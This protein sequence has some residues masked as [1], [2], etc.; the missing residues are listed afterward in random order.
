M[1]VFTFR[2]KLC[3]AVLLL[4]G[5]ATI[6]FGGFFQILLNAIIHEE[7]EQKLPIKNGTLAFGF[8]RDPPVPV[9]F[10]I[11]VFDVQNPD[12]VIA[13]KEA[14]SIVEK[15][16]YV[17]R[18]HL[19]KED[20]KWHQN[21]TV[22]YVQPQTYFFDREASVGPDTDTF[23]TINVPY[24]TI[25]TIMRFELP[26]LQKIIDAF[27][28]AKYENAFRRVSVHDI[29]WGYEDPVLEEAAELLKKFNITSSLINGKFGFYMEHN[30]TGDGM[31]NVFS[32]LDGNLDNYILVDR[33]NGL[34]KLTLWTTEY[35]NQIRGSD[36][37]QHPPYVTKD[38]SISIFDGYLQRSLKMCYNGSSSF[39][40]VRT[41]HFTVPYSEFAT[42][43][44]NPDNAGFCT[45]DIHHCIPSGAYN[46]TDATNYAPIYVSMP[47]FVG[48][49]P[50]YFKHVTGLHPDRLKHQ[51]FYD[52]HALTGVSLQGARRYQLVV[53]TESFEY[54]SAF[55][56]FPVSYLPILWIDGLAQMDAKTIALFRDEVQS[57]LDAM[58]TV[59]GVIFGLGGFIALIILTLIFIWKRKA[60]TVF[61]SDIEHLDEDRKP[62]IQKK[63]KRNSRVSPP[64]RSGDLNT[65]SDDVAVRDRRQN[66]GVITEE[67]VAQDSNN[68][69]PKQEN[70]RLHSG[71]NVES[72][73]PSEFFDPRT[74]P[75]PDPAYYKSFEST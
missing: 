19:H 58:P 53:R 69:E 6:L 24:I 40:G 48:G 16:P 70:G 35:A 20:I 27:V 56:N 1:T 2:R 5:L 49:D 75:V 65:H 17:Y 3:L 74:S 23:L 68:S 8:W 32:G 11:Y 46:M 18:M 57:T 72:D 50:Y 31:Y 13:G 62:L 55:K 21:G 73:G 22:S 45:P 66:G 42:A 14:P 30:N 29:W 38:T 52:I 61:T 67:R 39:M 60:R 59:R 44:E 71:S 36:G 34:K 47:H 7:L 51:P 37:S 12:E 28:R 33:W 25:A 9:Q 4:T 63:K 15:G 26:W 64:L 41:L 10:G 43:S 54:F